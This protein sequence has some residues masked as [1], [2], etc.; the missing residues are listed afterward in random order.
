MR[1]T[2]TTLSESSGGTPSPPRRE[3]DHRLDFARGL[4]LI[5]IFIDHIPQNPVATLTLRK[6]AFCDA[7][8]VFV[9]VS[10]IASYL[11]YGSR[12]DRYGLA[13]CWRAVGRRWLAIYVAHI[14]LFTVIAAGTSAITARFAGAD[15][16]GFLRLEWLFAHP[17]TAFEAALTL[18]YLPTY[19]D[20]LPLYLLL[21]AVAPILIVLVK[22]STPLLILASAALYFAVRHFGTNLTAD[23][24]GREWY[25]DPFAWQL[26]Y[27]IGIVIGHVSSE[28]KSHKLW[29]RGLL[30]VALVLVVFGVI[31]AAPWKGPDVGL[32]FFSS[33]IVLW[34]AEKTFLA[35]A[36]IVNLLAL[37][38]AFAFLVPARCEFFKGKIAAPFLWCGQH[39]LPVY[40]TSV[41][42]SCAGYVIM[43][44]DAQI[45]G[46]GLLVNVVGTASLI[47]LAAVLDQRARTVGI[48]YIVTRFPQLRYM[49]VALGAQSAQLD[50]R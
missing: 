17:K 27:V 32:D 18:R 16:V 44:E 26:V 24:Y 41:V 7:A 47:G 37:T 45:P 48:N 21:L 38:Y 2:D 31:A 10:G 42:L 46:I 6:L 33:G 11:A 8:E 15:Y 35:P 9:L 20:I 43:T 39:S 4:A 19:L 50:G 25:F 23:T 3:R 40:A 36:R 12:L 13:A 30:I 34:P 22:R 1:R 49:T 5:A 14:A 28:L 29:N